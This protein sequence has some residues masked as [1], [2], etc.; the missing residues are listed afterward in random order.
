MQ[1]TLNPFRSLLKLL[2][3]EE[4]LKISPLR[5]EYADPEGGI[6]A[7]NIDYVFRSQ[8]TEREQS[9]Q[10]NKMFKFKNF[11]IETCYGYWVPE[12]LVEEV[13]R[14]LSVASSRKRASLKRWRNWLLDAEDAIVDAYRTYLRDVEEMLRDNEVAWHEHGVSP[15]L[16]KDTEQIRR[17]IKRL[18]ATLSHKGWAKKHCQKYVDSEVP[19]IWEDERARTAFEDSFFDSFELKASSVRNKPRVVHL[20]LTAIEEVSS[21]EDL[22]AALKEC[23]RDPDWY[24]ENLKAAYKHP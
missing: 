18:Q 6:G 5:S 23:V 3:K 21:E 10:G 9:E 4:H 22:R 8:L 20:L 19:E 7:F 24:E 11:A 14:K 2:P 13:N 16:F 17:L 1:K 15:L 12:S